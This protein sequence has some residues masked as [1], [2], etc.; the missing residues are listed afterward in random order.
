MAVVENL[1]LSDLEGRL[2]FGN[3]TLDK[4]TKV[5]DFEA[6]GDLYKVKT[7]KEIT[8]LEK[9][10]LFV[11]ESVPGTAVFDFAETENEVSFNVEGIADTQITLEMAADT[12]YQ[13]FIDDVNIGHIRTNLGGKLVLSV[14]LGSAARAVKVRRL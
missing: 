7:F 13:V 1:I 14:E 10:D 2:S 6:G 8:K 12:E 9:N 11:Y 5:S 3:Y 4:K